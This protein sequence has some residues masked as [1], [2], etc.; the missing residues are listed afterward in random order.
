VTVPSID[1]ITSSLA[2][3]KM[4]GNSGLPVKTQFFT[5]HGEATS[6][7]GIANA[8]IDTSGRARRRNSTISRS[9]SPDASRAK[10]PT[11]FMPAAAPANTPAA[12]SGARSRR[13]VH[14]SRFS[15]VSATMNAIPPST[16]EAVASH[17]TS[18]WTRKIAALSSPTRQ[19]ATSRPPTATAAVADSTSASTA[20]APCTGFH[21]SSPSVISISTPNGWYDDQLHVTSKTRCRSSK[22]VGT[23][24]W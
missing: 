20:N 14:T 24:T 21:S 6:A 7:A 8:A 4:N 19:S 3:P 9:A 17:A 1:A 16:S 11:Y 12:M 18:G 2:P 15:A 23:E 22:S 13:I 10:R 5:Y